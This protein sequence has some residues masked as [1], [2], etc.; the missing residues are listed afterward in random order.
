MPNRP[1]RSTNAKG[2]ILRPQ[3]RA[4]SD[5]VAYAGSECCSSDTSARK[6]I[7][8]WRITLTGI[9]VAD[10]LPSMRYAALVLILTVAGC[11]ADPRVNLFTTPTDQGAVAQALAEGQCVPYA[12][13]PDP[14]ES[15]LI[16]IPGRPLYV[17]RHPERVRLW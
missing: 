9:L 8:R 6:A 2:V 17:C 16:R 14:A 4:A 10:I 5:R 13:V 12:R 11:A 1:P 7:A 15:Y 3:W